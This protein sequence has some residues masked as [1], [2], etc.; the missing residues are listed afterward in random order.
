M[1]LSHLKSYVFWKLA[2]TVKSF[3]DFWASKEL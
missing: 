1:V 3:E 2:F